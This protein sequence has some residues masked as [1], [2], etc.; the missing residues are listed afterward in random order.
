MIVFTISQRHRE[1][2]KEEE[3]EEEEEEECWQPSPPQA[4]QASSIYK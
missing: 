1:Q 4:S 2:A 3:E